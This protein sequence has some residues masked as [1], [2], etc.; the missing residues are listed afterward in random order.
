MMLGHMSKISICCSLLL[1]LQLAA[2][3]FCPLACASARSPEI[4]YWSWNSADDLSSVKSTVAYLLARVAVNGD[5]IDTVPRLERLKL[6]REAR[7]IAVVRIEV[8]HLPGKKDE[9]VVAKKLSAIVS[10]M[11]ARQP[12][13]SALQIDFDARESERPFYSKFLHELRTQT[14]GLP[15][16]ITALASW[17]IADRWLAGLPFDEVV[18]MCFS[19][20][21]GR[22]QALG[23]FKEHLP[24]DYAGSALG[25]CI[26]DR[27]P[28]KLFAERLKS[29]KRIY[30]FSIHGWNA[31]KTGM[32]NSLIRGEID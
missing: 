22:A 5:K 4:V 27:E 1:I 11:L 9:E 21:S 6:S 31:A 3:I 26:D 23:Y 18:P 20:G 25:L 19:L 32:A 15:L 13:L 8:E 24:F 17:C 12:R 29:Y 2:Q 28:I 7:R 30:L 10:A 16:S 14:P